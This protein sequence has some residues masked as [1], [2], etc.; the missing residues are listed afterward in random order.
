[1]T[2][3]EIR[4]EVR[5][6]LESEKWNKFQLGE[7]NLAKFQ[8]LDVLLDAVTAAGDP[9][10]AAEIRKDAAEVVKKNE[11]H[12]S[13]LYL[14]A[15]L[16]YGIGSL[17]DAS[18]QSQ[19]L[20]QHFQRKDKH[21]IVEH[22]A[23]QVLK[24]GPDAQA[25]RALIS[26]LKA[27][28]KNAEIE[29]LQE[30]LVAI[31]PGDTDLVI[32]LAGTKEK[33]GKAR[34]AL[35]Y[36]QLGLNAFVR[37]R[38]KKQVEDVWERIIALTPKFLDTLLPFEEA[39]SSN[40]DREFVFHL[41]QRLMNSYPDRKDTD[42]LIRLQKKLISFRPEDKELRNRLIELYGQKYEQHSQFG[43]F[44]I[45][46]GLKQWWEDVFQAI[47]RFERFI[48]FDVGH[49]VWHQS[50]GAGKIVLIQESA[51]YVDF[52][53]DSN[54][55]MTFDMALSSLTVVPPEHIKVFKRF[56]P[57][58]LKQLIEQDPGRTM[59][60]VLLSQN[61]RTVTVDGVRAELTDGLLPA[62]QWNRWWTR[63]RKEMKAGE[64]F[65]FPDSKTIRYIER[66]VSVEEELLHRFEDASDFAARASAAE[67]ALGLEKAASRDAKLYQSLPEYFQPLLVSTDPIEAIRSF[68]ILSRLKKV[69]K[70]VAVDFGSFDIAERLRNDDA[71]VTTFNALA[72]EEK[73]SF[74][75]LVEQHRPD[76]NELYFKLLTTKFSV[77]HLVLL[78]RVEKA[79]GKDRIT[80]FLQG[81]LE[82][83]KEMPD[84]FLGFGRQYLADDG[85]FDRFRVYTNFVYLISVLGRKIR[86]GENEDENKRIQKNVIALIFNRLPPNIIQF[87]VEKKKAGEAAAQTLVELSLDNAYLPEKY[88]KDIMD[89]VRKLEHIIIT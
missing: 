32:Q 63:A 70:D 83:Y 38:Q 13:A 22:L 1:M 26:S 78:D 50:W 18:W 10:L 81:V 62:D 54:H 74:L 48:K 86:N 19:R 31:E 11:Y 25:F 76:A 66:T 60:L 64:H 89:E 40:F 85:R 39:L 57:D 45:S 16:G 23:R 35:R 2:I 17:V 75:A 9:E 88:K 43:H 12:F 55:K 21:H 34:D 49:F 59:E 72:Q 58:E 29:G 82:N 30:K 61:T 4:A 6:I 79:L 68:L 44:L 71:V 56:R 8:E 37:D 14:S 20:I 28:G 87:I 15:V 27:Q 5:K 52:E 42:T 41:L 33:N 80:S 53:K 65:E 3:D 7:Y 51:M 77:F 69:R 84:V 67:T 73:K 47:D 36:F 46:S 24:F